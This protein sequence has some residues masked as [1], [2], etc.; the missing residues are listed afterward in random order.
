MKTKNI[1]KLLLFY[2]VQSLNIWIF[3]I[4]IVLFLLFARLNSRNSNKNSV[5]CSFLYIPNFKVL[6]KNDLQFGLSE[7]ILMDFV[8]TVVETNLSECLLQT[9]HDFFHGNQLDK[10]VVTEIINLMKNI[11]MRFFGKTMYF[12]SLTLEDQIYLTTINSNLL[13]HYC[14]AHYEAAS[15]GFDQFSWLL[16]TKT[17]PISKLSTLLFQAKSF[18]VLTFQVLFYPFKFTIFVL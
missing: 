4:L 18:F 1:L 15:T 6:P 16:A 7:S 10:K 14:L 12:R 3:W 11:F 5:I 9:L 2:F 8:E 17:P 13:I